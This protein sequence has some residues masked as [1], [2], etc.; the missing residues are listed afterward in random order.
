M[1]E[2]KDAHQFVNDL[3][4]FIKPKWSNPIVT[5]IIC[6]GPPLNLLFDIFAL[7]KNEHSKATIVLTI[8]A[9]I[10]IL[11]VWFSFIK[12]KKRY[13]K[14]AI[15]LIDIH[16]MIDE[17]EYSSKEELDKKINTALEEIL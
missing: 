2:K 4:R 17:D 14:Q 16:R 11:Y 5:T 10:F 9:I 12:A 1:I 3:T 6:S 13:K 7:K 8:I 15:A